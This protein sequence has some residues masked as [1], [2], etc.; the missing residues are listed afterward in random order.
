MITGMKNQAMTCVRK[1]IGNGQN[2]L[3]WFEPW[4]KAD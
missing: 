4:L 3:L 2:T 1:Q